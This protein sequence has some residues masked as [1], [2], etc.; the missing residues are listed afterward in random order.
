V[1]DGGDDDQHERRSEP[2]RP[3]NAYRRA[4]A[5]K[6]HECHAEAR[7]RT[8]AEHVGAGKGIAEEGLHLESADRQGG[9]GQQRD[10][11]LNQS[12]IQYDFRRC[13]RTIAARQGR[14]YI[15]ERYGN[16]PHRQ[17]QQKQ[18]KGEG[19]Q[20]GKQYGGMGAHLF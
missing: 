16:C 3:G 12:D 18:E 14:P 8:D 6:Y 1:A 13:S 2:S 5:C 19:G 7:A 4:D 17:I 15:A 20:R 9:S 10:H 11:R